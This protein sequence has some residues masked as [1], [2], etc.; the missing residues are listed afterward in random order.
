MSGGEIKG[1]E[2]GFVSGVLGTGGGDYKN[3]INLCVLCV[4]S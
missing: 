3:Q 1:G 4:Y 2:I